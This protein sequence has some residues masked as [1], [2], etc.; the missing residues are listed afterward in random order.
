MHRFQ[1]NTKCAYPTGNKLFFISYIYVFD[2]DFSYCYIPMGL[3]QL[4]ISLDPLNSNAI[5]EFL[6]KFAFSGVARAFPGGR[7][8]H[9]EGQNEEN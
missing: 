1:A 7:V 4:S 3:R 5:F 9:P 2:F 8:A 6:G